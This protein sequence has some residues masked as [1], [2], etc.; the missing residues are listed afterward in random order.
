M[1]TFSRL[2]STSMPL[3]VKVNQAGI[4]RQTYKQERCI[5]A[6]KPPDAT[7]IPV[8]FHCHVVA[9]HFPVPMSTM[10]TFRPSPTGV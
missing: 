6:R 4:D 7:A 9:F 1:Q 8:G 2:L 10:S 3:E 5:A